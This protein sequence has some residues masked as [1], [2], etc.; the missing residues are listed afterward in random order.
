MAAGVKSSVIA[1]QSAYRGQVIASRDSYPAT[2][3]RY[4]ALP[5]M[6]GLALSGR[7]L[8]ARMRKAVRRLHAAEPLR[9]IHAHAALPCGYAAALL[10]RDLRIPF[11]VTVHGRDVFS[12]RQGGFAADWCERLSKWVYRSAACVICVS[13]KVQEE[14]S[15]G[16]RCRSVVVY[17]GVDAKRFCPGPLL[18]QSERMVLCVGNLLPS[19]GHETLLQ[20]IARIAADD[21]TVRCEIVG[22]GPERGR[23]T[24]LALQLGITERV[25]FL[26][27]QSREWVA[28]AMRRCSVFALPS[29][30]EGLGCVYLEAMATGKPTVACTGQGIGEIIDSGRNGY[31]IE[32]NQAR[33]L[34]EILARVLRDAELRARLGAAARE[35]VVDGL[36]L[37]HQAER[38][39]CAYRECLP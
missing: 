39:A 27:R 38:L 33:A 12:S 16:V 22:T 28:N 10:A 1:V 23:L 18:P 35:T 25:K 24:R 34:S 13:G 7:S 11:V 3:M 6:A 31:L 15:A 4:P 9:L 8:Y 32:P 26:E 30:Y 17:N 19:K 21:S 2:W 29:A 36:T 37:A 5:R 14:L 20:S